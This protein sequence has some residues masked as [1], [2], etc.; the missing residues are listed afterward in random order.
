MP[1][2]KGGTSPTYAIKRL[3]RDNPD[4][5]EKVRS[6]ELSANKAAIE[7]GIKKPMVQIRAD[8][9]VKAAEQMKA[10][11]SSE[12]IEELVKSLQA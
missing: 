1:K 6:G 10:K 11:F 3:K 2:P 7:A 5:F 9:P 12:F 8:D 4:L